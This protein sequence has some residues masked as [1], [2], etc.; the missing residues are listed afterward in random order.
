MHAAERSR[1][2]SPERV[3]G[4]FPALSLKINGFPLSYLD[5]AATTQ[6]PKVVI[7]RL[8]YFYAHE[9]ANIH[10]GVHRLAE[11]ATAA[12]EGARE[13]VR[14]F[15]N[16]RSVEEIVFVRGT[17]EAINLVAAS[18]GTLWQRGDEVVV[19]AME[20]HANIV[21]WQLLAER[22]GIGV[23]VL[24]MNEAG[25]LEVEKLPELLTPRTRLVA[26]T[27]VSN[28]LGTMNP[29]AEIVRMAHAA[30]AL[31]L[32]DGAQ[33][34]S[35]LAAVD[36]Q[37]LGAD[38]Y[39]FSGHKMF[40]P[41]GIGVLYGRQELLAEMPPYQGGGDMIRTV[42]FAGSTFADPPYRFEAGTPP[43]A[44]AVGLGCAIDYLAQWDRQAAEEYEQELLDYTIARLRAVP[45]VR[46]LGSPQRRIGVV[47]FTLAGVHAHDL[48]TVLDRYGVAIRVGHHC[49]MPVMDFYRVPATARVSL[50]MYN[51][52]EEIDQMVMALE[53]AR[54]LLG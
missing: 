38:F 46:V 28:V 52:F 47:S 27:H 49:A 39:C 53:E 50:A 4:D 18:L 9:N 32:V 6:K 3:R 22:Q 24:P 8:A 37:A 14:R 20:H 23:R 16:A 41:T 33:A 26:V 15:V 31:V 36:V 40:A 48:G 54:R 35:H 29:I 42:S 21:P 11:L 45:G 5:N 13:R 17:T 12:Y 1:L 44:E 30:G 19:S 10:R 51:T 25:E 34:V 2:W 7:E 43:I